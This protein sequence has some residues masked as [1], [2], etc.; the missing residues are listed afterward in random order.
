[1]AL[2]DALARAKPKRP[3][4]P[5]PTPQPPS[6]PAATATAAAEGQAGPGTAAG[7][8]SLGPSP[9]GPSGTEAPGP[10]SAAP[11]QA[12]DA[13]TP[14]PV[15]GVS[16]E[17]DRGA[18]AEAQEGTPDRGKKKVAPPPRRGRGLLATL[19]PACVEALVKSNPVAGT[20]SPSSTHFPNVVLCRCQSGLA[21][22]PV[23]GPVVCARTICWTCRTEIRC[24]HSPQ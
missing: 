16:L 9:T 7:D 6:T 8:P 20:P 12:E 22:R 10:G 1:M 24:S 5:K 14:E 18:Q 15:G 2:V 19:S 11:S 23:D 4:R 3:P 13:P 21:F 17:T